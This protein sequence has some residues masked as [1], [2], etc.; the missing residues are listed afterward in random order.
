MKEQLMQR[1]QGLRAEFDNGRKMLAEL[2]AKQA[3]LNTSLLRIDGA[4]QVLEELL[5]QAAP[6]D[7]PREIAGPGNMGVV[8][9]G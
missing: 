9:T 4:I 6:E 5:S 2:A 8:A 3:S 1:L 7:Q